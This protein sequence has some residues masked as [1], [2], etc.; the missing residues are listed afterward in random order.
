MLGHVMH[1]I[2]NTSDLLQATAS[3]S[4]NTIR[5]SGRY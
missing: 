5:V 1:D 3:D 4:F 2:V